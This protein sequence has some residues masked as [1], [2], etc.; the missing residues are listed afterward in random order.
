[1]IR[2]RERLSYAAGDVG[3]NLIWQSIELYLLFFYI[4]ILQLPLGIAA[5]IFLIGAVVDWLFDPVIGALADR[6]AARYPMRSWVLLSGPLIAVA[7]WLA[8]RSPPLA[9][10]NLAIYAAV[11]HVGLRFAYGCGNIPYAVLTARI[12][13]DPSEQLKLTGLRMQGAALGGLTAATIY[14]LT[15]GNDAPFLAGALILGLLA[16]PCFFITWIGVKERVAAP[17]MPPLSPG[18]EISHYFALVGSNAALRRLLLT[19]VV[20]GLSTTVTAK[21]ILFLFDRDLG[22]SE[23]GY[24]AALL[25]SAALLITAPLWVSLSA[26]VGLVATLIWAVLLHIGALAMLAIFYSSGLI[27]ATITL[28][29]AIAATCGMSIMFWSMVPI[30]IRD[31]E[32]LPDGTGCAAH[33]YALSNVARKLGQALAPQ[34]IALSLALTG[35]ADA[36]VK[37]GAVLP[38]MILA[39]VICCVAILLYRPTSERRAEAS[40]G[41]RF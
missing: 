20:A 18:Q 35:G 40:A 19:I 22:N 30:A 21:S 1:M 41:L 4:Q 28:A 9:G 6:M 27:V 29:I 34:I 31:I 13:D 11:T 24:W 33:V 38:G 12:T 15:S 17:P 39:A 10:Y 2:R 8:F 37:G 26:R 36:T 14:A 25:P 16:Q 5:G 23:W 32:T 3:F 7:L